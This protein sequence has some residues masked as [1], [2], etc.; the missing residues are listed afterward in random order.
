[1]DETLT[2]RWL[3]RPNRGDA[4]F[5]LCLVSYFIFYNEKEME[6]QNCVIAVKLVSTT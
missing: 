1:M 2:C 3:M 5:K 6:K 4:L